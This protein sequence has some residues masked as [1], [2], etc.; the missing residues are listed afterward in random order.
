MPAW[1]GLISATAFADRGAAAEDPSG[2]PMHADTAGAA[3]DD[4]DPDTGLIA[5]DARSLPLPPG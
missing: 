4:L 2:E 3:L 1:T 5:S